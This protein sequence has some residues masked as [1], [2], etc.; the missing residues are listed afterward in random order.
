MA[1]GVGGLLLA[2]SF[3]RFCGAVGKLRVRLGAEV[4]RDS[5]HNGTG[6]CAAW[7]L[8]GMFALILQDAYEES[9]DPLPRGGVS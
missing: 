9:V 4:I 1:A 2:G 3:Q 5:S 8:E 7:F 6:K